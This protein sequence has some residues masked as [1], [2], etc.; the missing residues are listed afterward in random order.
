MATPEQNR[1]EEERAI[2]R[3]RLA[4][5]RRQAALQRVRSQFY[6]A[7]NGVHD[8]RSLVE[9]ERAE[10]EFRDAVAEMDRITA[11]ICTGK[12]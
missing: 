9:L 6:P 3:E 11:E 1:L 2:E 7:G 5:E 4:F 8:D 10:A 12:R